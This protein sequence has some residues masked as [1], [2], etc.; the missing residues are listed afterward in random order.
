MSQVMRWPQR[1]KTKNKAENRKNYGPTDRR[2]D[3]RSYKVASEQLKNYL[4]L[5]LFWLVK[6]V[7]SKIVLSACF[8]PENKSPPNWI[9]NIEV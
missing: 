2:T 7:G 4:P 8:M 1:R 6:L 9:K 3:K 5:N